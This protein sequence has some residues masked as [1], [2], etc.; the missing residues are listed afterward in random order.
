[1]FVENL[2]QVL[3]RADADPAVRGVILTGSHARGMAAVWSGYDVV[4]VVAE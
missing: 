1:V 2:E 4:I 3:A